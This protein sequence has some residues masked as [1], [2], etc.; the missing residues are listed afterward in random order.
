MAETITLE[1]SGRRSDEPRLPALL[2]SARRSAGEPGDPFLPEGYLQARASF[3]VGAVARGAGAAAQRYATQDDEVLLI[4]LADGGVLISSAGRLK[5][6]LERNRPELV[7]GGGEIL[8]DRLRDDSSAARGWVG[9]A[10]GGLVN[11]VFVFTVGADSDAIIDQAREKLAELIADRLGEAAGDKLKEL[12]ELGVSWLGTKALMWAIERRLDRQ[13]GLYCW[14]DGQGSAAPEAAADREGWAKREL[15]RAQEGLRRAAAEGWPVL[16]F[17]HGMGAS[18]R[19]SFGELLADHGELWSAL[20]R[21]FAGGIYAFEHRTLSESPIENALDLLAALPDG[22]QVSVVS[23]SRGGLI[24]DLLCLASFHPLIDRYTADLPG[25]GDADEEEGQR[26]RQQLD[27]AHATQRAQLRQLA[28]ELGRRQLVVQRYLR[29][30]SPAQGSKL[31]SGNLD[32][33]LSGVLTLIGQLPCF[34]GSPIYS[35]FKR[36]V[37]EIARRRTNAH[38]VP[39]IEAML[40]D[41]PLARLL[42]D[43]PVRAGVD[44]A[45]IAGDIEGG[46]L[47]QRLGVWLTDFVFFDRVANDLVV[48]TAS[49]FAGI[50]PQ[51]QARALFERGPEVSHFR[52]FTNADTRVALRDWLVA[53]DPR[54]LAAFQP[55]PGAFADLEPPGADEVTRGALPARFPDRPVVVL[56]PGLM[57]SHLWLNGRDRVW[58]DPLDIA[59]GGLAKIA[60]GRPGIEA[61]K[62]FAMFY[63]DLCA[64]L[65]RSQRVERFAYDWRQPLD[66]LAERL[67][68][69]LAR[70]LDETKQPVRLLAHS[71]GGLLVRACHYQRPAVIDALMARDGAR[72]VMLG[73]PNQGTYSMVENLL[74]KGDTLRSLARLDVGHSLR[75]LLGIVAG[76]RG[77]LQLLPRPGFVDCFQGEPGGGDAKPNFQAAE[78]WQRLRE[79]VTDLWFGQGQSATPT[80]GELDAASW[81]WQREKDGPPALPEAWAAKTIYVFGVARHT[82]CGLREE[83]TRLRLVGT[84]QGDGVVTW[85]SGRIGN[86]GSYYYMPVRHGDLASTREYFPALGELLQS[87]AT[88]G[89]LRSPPALRGGESPLPVAYDAGPPTLAGS[90]AM[91]RGLLGGAPRTRVAA[92]PKRRLT[93]GVKAMDLRFLTQPVLLGHYEQ[94]PIAG[95][96]ALVD[97]ELLD[98]DLSQRYQ[99]G[100]YAGPRGTA[101]VVLRAPNEQERRRGSLRGAVVCGLGAYDGNLSVDT[102][103]EAV[104]AGVL[105]YLL[106][107]IDVLGKEE[108]ELPLAT[109][110]L[111]YNSSASLSVAASV[112]ALLRGV[113]EANARFHETTRL[114]IRVGRVD[115]VEL[116]QDTAITAVYALREMPARLAELTR[117][118]AMVLACRPELEQGDG[119]RQRLFDGAAQS[120]WPR[121]MV[122]DASRPDRESPTVAPPSAVA[123]ASDRAAPT[124]ESAAGQPRTAIAE[125]LRFLCVGQRA[126]AETIVHQRQPGLVERLVRQQIQSARWQEDFGRLLFQ[127]M[128]PHDFKDALRQLESIVLM[129]D[130]YTA[131]LPWE[132]MLADQPGQ[133]GNGLP[134]A[135]RT[136]VVRQLAAAQFRRQVRQGFERQALVVG[137]PSVEGFA[138]AFPDPRHPDAGEPPDLAGAESEANEVATILQ[139][140]GYQVVQAIGRDCR[141]AD[142][143]TRLYQRAYRLLHVSAHGVFDQPHVAGGRRSGV[144]LSDGLLLTAAEIRAMETVPELVFLS[145]CHL[146]KVDADRAGSA[147]ASRTVED[148]NLL[149]ASVARELI[150]IGVRCVVVAGWAIDDQGAMIFGQTFYRSLLLERRT[151]G[152]AVF[153]ARRAVWEA[154]PEDITWGAF[155][156]YG[157]PG[158]RAEARLAGP[159]DDEYDYASPDELLDELLSRRASLARA[160]QRQ[161]ARQLTAMKKSLQRLLEERCPAAWQRLPAVQSAVAAMCFELEDF[162]RARTAYL[163]AIQAEDGAGR[164]PIR[165]IEQLANAEAR[166]GEMTD[167]VE[168]IESALHRL[169][170]L[171]ELLAGRADAAATSHS[172]RQA[173]CGSAAKRKAS[174]FAKRVLESPVGEARD[175]AI[176]AMNA[177]LAQSAE[178]YA[179]GEGRPGDATFRPYNVL[180]R[181]AIAALLGPAN[182]AERLASVDLARRCLQAAG[183]AYARSGDFW[184]AIMCPES[185]LVERLLDGRLSETGDAGQAAFDELARAYDEALAGLPATPKKLDS[186]VTQLRLLST[187]CA[188]RQLADSD[189]WQEAA[190]RLTT[191][192]GRIRRL[193]ERGRE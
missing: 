143:L 27:D 79:K 62:P 59:G 111:G 35:A 101:T 180:N 186:V 28:S 44:M 112:E 107:V 56:L 87:G 85:A 14:D 65:A 148:G 91:A 60:W 173:L 103:T 22:L 46:R 23:H 179:Q 74:G 134:L 104:R 63:A 95:A 136:P 53:G 191:L 145:C 124:G 105:R 158:W 80:Q 189:S 150:A 6:S 116:Y 70:L 49:M 68:T 138:K 55:L 176:T 64:F 127:S 184:D 17:I 88:A 3:E 42:R 21:R 153:A 40:P 84:T 174:L 190:S 126:R 152:T 8:F 77:A 193:P 175:E 78:T 100:I 177:A 58:F 5:A 192:A 125:R 10:V 75:E 149:A 187:F 131:N 146:G 83:A 160:T 37:L 34:F 32:L 157:D 170:K 31:A 4:E 57:G 39:G 102:L 90:E 166:L 13:P 114:A 97:R 123:P 182:E 76:F 110:L 54:S 109:L 7:G 147:V 185:L 61:E 82:P 98:G 29:V 183:E 1:L 133:S 99:L 139:S 155:Q 89:L 48:D 129:V 181:L 108:R 141:A 86:I 30:A 19:S 2:Q 137:N 130:D 72:F 142:V 161:T 165:D 93:V 164:V 135:V 121:L 115:I 117:R 11:R 188:A 122:T 92:R 33:F 41:S 172:E 47:W 96:E 169:Q 128:I 73:T 50:A 16:V 167:N 113:I 69:F 106:Q 118:H 94:D 132:L 9:E 159:A 20:E 81:L 120:Y 171:E 18:A 45:V 24:A 178:F 36:V 156:A 168:L 52:Y 15:A 162:A 51:A 26:V 151:F 119:L 43:A 12:A 66:V 38:L 71:A 163:A 25:T 154:R 67:A 144:V 140:L